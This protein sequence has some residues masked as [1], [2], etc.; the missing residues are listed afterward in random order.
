MS[1]DNDNPDNHWGA[2]LAL[3]TIMA[4]GT[5]NSYFKSRRTAT[6]ISNGL[7]KKIGE[8]AD[9]QSQ[10][11]VIRTPKKRTDPIVPP[12]EAARKKAEPCVTPVKTKVGPTLPLTPTKR[13]KRLAPDRSTSHLP[14]RYVSLLDLFSAFDHLVAIIQ[15][16]RD[17]CTFTRLRNCIELQTKKAFN[18]VRLSQIMTVLPQAYHLRYDDSKSDNR[19]LMERQSPTG[20][21]A[22]YKLVIEIKVDDNQVRP[23]HLEERRNLF[24]EKLEELTVN[25]PEKDPLT[26]PE[27][28]EIEG[29]QQV[30]FTARRKLNF[31]NLL[32]DDINHNEI[33]PPQK[34]TTTTSAKPK[35]SVAKALFTPPTTPIKSSDPIVTPIKTTATITKLLP[36]PKKIST[37]PLKG[38]SCTLLDR[39]RSKEYEVNNSEQ[40]RKK[41]LLATLPELSRTI[42]TFF[43]SEKKE[44]LPFDKVVNR[45]VTSS[46]MSVTATTIC[47]S[48][49]LLLEIVPKWISTI[50]ITRGRYMRINRTLNLTYVHET[51]SNFK[52]ES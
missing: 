26:H 12:R 19:S 44:C 17:D 41:E 48:I 10:L 4:D 30:T 1:R 40:M 29:Y 45:C 25:K 36:S 7:K 37:G 2:C 49:D 13:A 42:H 46:T 28:L 23:R 35:S 33:Q 34:T 6:P 16:R 52:I 21:L 11:T 9:S 27:P 20:R 39:I 31:D 24:K 15:N 47:E 32:R 22:T 50:K 38:I 8:V 18:L 43:T 14:E 5:I 51:I 3:Y